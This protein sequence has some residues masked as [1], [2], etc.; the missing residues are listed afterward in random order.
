MRL[1]SKIML[2]LIVCAS[3][4]CLEFPDRCEYTQACKCSHDAGE[5]DADK[6]VEQLGLDA[7]A[8]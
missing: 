4:G 8:H 5:E 2:I 6:P 7:G 1:M 3:M